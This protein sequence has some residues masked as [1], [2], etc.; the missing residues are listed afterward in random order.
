[1]ND[2]LHT[3]SFE[4][5]PPLYSPGSPW[6]DYVGV[7]EDGVKVVPALADSDLQCY[8]TFELMRQGSIL[9][10]ATEAL[11]E[12]SDKEALGKRLEEAEL[13]GGHLRIPYLSVEDFTFP[14]FDADA[15]SPDRPEIPLVRYDGKRG[16]PNETID[17]RCD[18]EGCVALDIPQPASVVRPSEPDPSKG[19]S[20]GAVVL[21]DRVHQTEY[22]F[23]QA[24]VRDAS[25]GE[26]GG[27]FTGNRIIAA[28]SVSRFDYSSE[29]LGAHPPDDRRRGA[30]RASGLPYLGGLL[31]P[32]DFK[33]ENLTTE[34]D[35][36]GLAIQHALAFT[37]P[38]MRYLASRGVGSVGFRSDYV[39]PASDLET[40]MG[41][42]NPFALA[43][44][45]RIR[46]KDNIVNRHGRGIIQQELKPVTQIFL[47]TLKDYGA[48]LVDG[49]LAFGFAAEDFHTAYVTLSAELVSWLGTS[50]GA[51]EPSTPKDETAWQ[52]LMGVLAEDL[53]CAGFVFAMHI[54]EG[55]IRSNFEVVS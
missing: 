14:I 26:G 32:E 8:A 17:F 25:G 44:G 41:T 1:M 53:H 4:F 22:N 31:I 38:G 34:T 51:E 11:G 33:F 13:E 28:G 24:T 39:F 48:Y 47:N 23:W 5:E 15:A 27:G 45:Q 21:V 12:N 30:S 50:P 36:S 10:V 55:V 20:D 6:R 2:E 7:G 19:E 37:L 54:G 42:V 49:A 40:S 29:G 46:L 16:F 9:H 35:P 3:R 18:G 43:A 52:F